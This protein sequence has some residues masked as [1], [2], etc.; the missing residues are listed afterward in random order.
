MKRLLPLTVLLASCASTPQLPTYFEGLG[1]G[2]LEFRYTDVTAGL[3]LCYPP[4]PTNAFSQMRFI[5][6]A[7]PG[8]ATFEYRRWLSKEPTVE[9]WID[10]D[11]TGE[12]TEV[13]VRTTDVNMG[14]P[15]YHSLVAWL[16]HGF[17]GVC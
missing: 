10:N 3:V 9:I 13:R 5:S 2:A 11:A 8:W 1:N 14:Q 17:N 4:K 16:N 15:I 6:A 12:G 7:G